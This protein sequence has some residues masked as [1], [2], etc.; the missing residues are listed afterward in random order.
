MTTTHA[1]AGRPDAPAQQPEPPRLEVTGTQV[2]TSGLASVSAAV[3]ASVFGVAGT[4]VGA[5][6]VSVVATVGSAVYGVW[7]RRTQ[8]RLQQSQA[9]RLPGRAR[10][11][12]GT[13]TNGSAAGR[14]HATDAASTPAPQSPAPGDEDS[15]QPTGGWRAWLSRRR[16]GVAT[17][18]VT[19]LVSSLAVVTLIELAGQRPL[20][21]ITGHEP[22]GR[23]SI[24]S[25]FGGGD[26]DAPSEQT[27]TTTVPGVTPTDPDGSPG[28]PSSP[29]E[30]PDI[31]DTTPSPTTAEQPTTTPTTLA[32]QTPGTADDT[33]G[34]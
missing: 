5:A 33:I 10:S 1:R 26:T 31:G 22:S 25:L 4:V 3:V 30:Q 29:T 28:A 20:S 8:T 23:T 34:E 13:T 9:I 21:A 6:V 19:V 32:P 11:G 24:G 14:R 15:S 17:A 7:I 18:A 2:L 16:W 27:P 12:A